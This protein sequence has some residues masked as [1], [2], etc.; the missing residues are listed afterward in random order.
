MK[1]PLNKRV[2][3]E[4]G[5]DKGKFIALFL[6]LVILIGFISGF[7]VA[8]ESMKIA[9][10][11]SFTK[12][13]IEDGHFILAAEA[14]D[15]LI[16]RLEDEGIKVRELFYKDKEIGKDTVR[17]YKN[18]E[19]VNKLS[20]LDGKTPTADNEIAIDRLYAENNKLSINDTIKIGDVDFRICGL[21]AFSDYSA[22]FKNNTDMMFDAKN[23]TVAVVTEKSFENIGDGGLNYCYAWSNNKS[24]TNKQKSEKADD[25]IDILSENALLTDFVK[26]SDNQAITFTGED[27]GGDKA[28]IT[29]MLYIVIVI[30]AF[31]FAIT[32]R[33]TIE[34]EASVIGTLRASGYTRGELL[35]H[36]ITLPLAVTLAAAI[37]GNICGYT[38]MK[39]FVAEIYYGSYSLPTYKTVWNTEAF[40]LTTLIPGIIILVVNL[41]VISSA[42]SLPPLQFLRHELKKKKKKKVARLPEF[43]FITRFRIRII[44][45]NLSAYITMFIGILLASIMLMFGL[46]MGPLLSNFKT[47]V[48]DSKFAD[49]QYIL[50]VPVETEN[51]KAE[52]YCAGSLETDNGEEITVYGIIDNS[53]YIDTDIPT[54]E[55]EILVS[56][57]YMEKYSL[58]IGDTITLSENFTDN[59]H[60]FKVAG[61][62]DYAAALSIFMSQECFNKAF[63]MDENYFSGYFSNEKLTDIDESYI[64]SL[65]TEKD[66]TVLADQLE[67]NVGMMVPM[68]GG[69]AVLL[70]ILMIY[71][72]AKMII[73]KNT[74]SISMIKILGYSNGE[75]SRL[76]NRS[77]AIVVVLSLIISLPI[78]YLA[79]EVIFFAMLQEMNGWLTFYI[80]PWIFPVIIAVGIVC[81]SIVHIIQ[82]KKIR[83]IPMSQA[84]KNVE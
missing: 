55:N 40:I 64:A 27:I 56:N 37:I 80:A 1:N 46:I 63:D 32:T 70:Y 65:I 72:L 44:L 71:L 84:L 75:A 5:Q 69:F 3:R 47:E 24:L 78:C 14:D 52:K 31:V 33:S 8:D 38:F 79:M 66:L 67:E 2:F 53:N 42:L 51:N 74:Q 18:R 35:R 19:E 48:I 82:M 76:Y 4:L 9:Y 34:R 36:Y 59:K 10:D 43:K 49:Y 17:V 7:L 30:L 57:G 15:E 50:K 23:F 39:D 83:K 20:I 29:W 45:Q 11:E 16:S 21:A 6:F 26:Q 68:F 28:M 58:N 81:Y 41:I 54:G 25:L 13:N 62:I 61:S 77:T 22:L 73:E 60:E 12:Y